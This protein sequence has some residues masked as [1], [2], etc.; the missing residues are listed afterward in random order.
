MA[1]ATASSSMMCVRAL[2]PSQ[3]TS[4]SVSAKRPSL[5]ALAPARGVSVSR[6]SSSAVVAAAR[7]LW[8]PESTPP[9][10]LKGE[11]TGDFGFD[12]LN[13]GV[14]PERLKW[15]AEGELTNGRWAM[16][17]VAGIMFTDL[18]NIGNVDWFNAGA[19]G[20]AAGPDGGPV[21]FWG[22]IAIEAVV[23]GALEV[24][25]YRNW[26]KTGYGGFWDFAPFDPLGLD[27]PENRLKEVKNGRLAMIAF[28]GFM[29]QALAT[30]TGPI[31]NL[32]AHLGNPFGNNIVSSIA[33]LPATLSA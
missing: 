6:R 22:L 17:A 21:P 16:A 5:K 11:L 18:L 4:R 3:L 1:A 14:D 32:F 10:H 15:Y 27:S 28:A 20:G 8:L 29:V 12:P 7:P 31:D 2:S 30:R 33:N 13:F 25:R 9:A 23:F 24:R 26:S 19:S